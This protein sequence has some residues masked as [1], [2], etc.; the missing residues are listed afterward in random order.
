[1]KLD[2]LRFFVILSLLISVEL[3]AQHKR[4]NI[5]VIMADDI[6]LGDIGYYHR[7]RTN[8]EPAA[9]TPNL[10]KLAIEGMRF[11]DAHSP[12]SMCAPTRFSM[13]T[14]NY[15]YRNRN[16]YG[17]WNPD[18]DALIDSNSFTTSA[19]IAKKGGYTTAFF[20]KWGLGGSWVPRQKVNYEEESAGAL[21]YGFDYAVELPVGI[22][23][24]PYAFYE[25]RKW[26]KLRPNSKLRKLKVSQTGY[27]RSKKYTNTGG[28]GD[29]YWDPK[30]VGP[31]LAGKAV[32]YINGQVKTKDKAPFFLYYCSQAVHIPHEA[33]IEFDGKKVAGTT[34]GKHG[35]MIYEL[36]IQI[37]LIVKALKDNGLY[38]NT[39]FIF[40]S[41]NGGLAFDKGM[42]KAGHVTSNGLRKSKGSIYEGGHRVPFIA[43]W[44]EKI[45][46]NT[47]SQE[48]IV[49]QD[50]V[51]TI[52]ALA[53]QEL[54]KS[55]VLDSAN[56]LP[57][58]LGES[59]NK[60]PL[61]KYLIHQSNKRGTHYAIREGKW[62]LIIQGKNLK[63]AANLEPMA[64]FN[65]DANLFEDEAKNLINRP[66]YQDRVKSMY[67][68]YLELRKNKETTVN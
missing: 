25:N 68:K 1:M 45:S 39:L 37:G 2:K 64:L 20:G 9:P 15:S 34:P 3:N 19:R 55:Q 12:A 38:N 11:T 56:L 44:P 48:P 21:I 22:Q 16:P 26:M 35:D 8:K 33:P 36:D 63:K 50:V 43:V 59:K 67:N 17:V 52:A 29:S 6:G 30:Q 27:L 53:N 18:A 57:I 14:G 31:I 62:K 47:D 24:E 60:E 41:D 54:D 10:D 4:P 61:H 42:T 65:L 28:L 66:K 32:D 58:L 46:P 23:N 40:T 5:V 13:L 49:S 51:A 7:L